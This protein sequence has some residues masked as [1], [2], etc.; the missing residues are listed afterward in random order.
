METFPRHFHNG[1]EEN[2]TASY[3]SDDPDQA[4]REFL[5]F[6]RANLPLEISAR[7]QE[8]PDSSPMIAV[9]DSGVGGLSVWR[10]IVRELPGLPTVY[11]ADQAHIPYGPRP[12]EEVRRFAEGIT[13]FLLAQGARVVVLACN[14]ASAAAL[15]HLRALFPQVPFVGMEPAV[16]P[17][18]QRTRNGRVGVIA[19]PA[20]FQGELFAS[21]LER[22]AR[23]VRV[24]PQVCPGLVE[25]VEAGALDTPET[26][27]LLRGCLEPLLAAGIDELVLGCTHYP[28]LRPLMERMVGPGVEIIDPAPAVARQVRRVVENRGAGCQ[29]ARGTGYQPALHTFYTTGDPA[30][31]ARLLERLV[32]VRAE[33]RPLCWEGN[34]IKFPAADEPPQGIVGLSR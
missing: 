26:E 29:P 12:L 15:H 32:G 30:R 17:A 34:E 5:E 21:L 14:T 28:F 25:A 19:T 18:A 23:D 20:T 31:F 2:V 3:I 9:F 7:F 8:S 24:I 27:A 11:L 16:K 13:R 1:S 6:A 33:V 4:L 10:E 22:F